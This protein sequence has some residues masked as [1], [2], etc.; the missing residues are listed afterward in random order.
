MSRPQEPVRRRSATPGGAARCG[1]LR[2]SA[3]AQPP[4]RRK[5]TQWEPRREGT[6][7][8][9]RRPRAD[10]AA[11]FGGLKGHPAVSGWGRGSRPGGEL[12]RTPSSGRRERGGRYPKLLTLLQSKLSN[13]ESGKRTTRVLRG[14]SHRSARGSSSQGRHVQNAKIPNSAAPS[15]LASH[16]RRG[17]C[18][19]GREAPRRSLTPSPCPKRMLGTPLPRRPPRVRVRRR[20]GGARGRAGLTVTAIPRPCGGATGATLPACHAT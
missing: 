16:C 2:R 19:A 18:S 17:V 5:A 14:V 9:T 3:L 10:F 8:P 4:S 12:L 15:R 1:A 13:M 11:F 7:S 6:A 20:R